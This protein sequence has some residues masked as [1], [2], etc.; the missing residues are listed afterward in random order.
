MVTIN[1][2]LAWGKTQVGKPYCTDWNTRFGPN[3]YDCSGLVSQVLWHSG[4]PTT[5]LPTNSADITRWLLAHPSYRIDKQRARDTPGA[6]LLLGG[7]NGY[8][9]QGHIGLS[10]GGGK[11]LESRGSKHGVGI[12]NLSDIAWDDFMLAPSVVYGGAPTPPAPSPQYPI[13]PQ[14]TEM[15]LMRGDKTPHVW[16]VNGPWKTHVT[17]EAY[18]GWLFIC[19]SVPG[20]VDPT[21][22]KEWVVPQVMI[23]IITDTASIATKG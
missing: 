22:K 4:M 20:A 14:E 13:T 7:P 19:N 16:I 6:V 12:Y 2:G 21:T 15:K 3:C 18:P 10:L 8:G 9:P 17:S 11:T 5:A 1:D 23:D